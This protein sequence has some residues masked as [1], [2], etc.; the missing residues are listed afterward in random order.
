VETREV[1]VEIYLEVQDDKVEN[2]NLQTVED[3]GQATRN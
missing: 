1:A 3:Q 2:Y